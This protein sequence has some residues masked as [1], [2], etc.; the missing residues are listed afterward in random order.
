MGNKKILISIAILLFLIGG[1]YIFKKYYEPIQK[2]EYEKY[3]KEY[4]TKA[5]SGKI[6]SVKK[7]EGNQHYVDVT[8][9]DDSTHEKIVYKKLS[10][11]YQPLLISFIE[12][13]D[14][15]VKKANEETVTILKKNGFYKSF[16][17]Y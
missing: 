6:E 14:I 1:G 17:L 5:F 12:V 15:I 10:Y 16:V 7:Y 11:S 3:Q 13:G 8:I 2:I 4:V 9:V